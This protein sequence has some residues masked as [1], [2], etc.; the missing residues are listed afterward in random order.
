MKW[1]KRSNTL[2]KTVRRY[3]LAELFAP[4]AKKAWQRRLLSALP[5]SR[6]FAGE[7][8]PVRLRLALES[9][10]PVFVKFGQVLSTRPDLIPHDY[11]VELAKLQD[12]VPPFD[13]D[14]SR[15]Q[16]EKALGRPVARLYA[17]FETR[18]VASASVAQVHRARL[19][20]GERVAVKVLR[21]DIL[22][23][24]EQDLAL[25][26]F[27]AGWVER[28]FADGKRLR[29]REVV[30]EF[31]K[32]LHD[33]LDL[34]REA[35]NCS[36]LG[37]NFK[38]SKMLIV[39]KVFYDYCSRD[40]L[41]IEWMDGTPVSD[42]AA[43]RAQGQ[44]LHKL[45]E[46]GVETFFTQV[47]RDGFFHAD[48]HPGNILVSADNRYIALD[49]GIV[50]SLTDYDK[51]YLAINFLAFFNRD[52][53]RVATAHIESGWVPPETRAE[54]LEAAV[55]AVCE[56]VFNKPISQI[57]FGLVLMRLFEVSRRFNVEIQPQLVLLQKTLLNIEGLGRQLEP[58]LDLW[59]TAKPFLVK[60]MNEQVG[61][62]AFWRNLKNEAPDWA[63]MLP[64]LPRKLNALVDEARQKE[65]RDAYVHLVKIQ[66]RQSLWLAVIAAALVLI[67]LF[68]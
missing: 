22:P 29:P 3:G 46:Y 59:A 48:M 66:Q 30:D 12:K 53:H 63:E 1:L 7:P 4:L 21:P 50:G 64:A 49:F 37:R 5:P 24:I 20:G 44:D 8:L 14:V 65:M 32:Y 36:Q 60:W 38:D 17:E 41:T 27:G 16:I 23:V 28:L 51:R 42:I 13:A 25:L 45:A 26:R 10:G 62:K 15:R 68:K 67:V 61:P 47:F 52:Y 19:H 43:L 56:P 35:A 57:S 54:E 33:E 55:R 2:W 34:M 39:P 40:V 11:A 31:D 6:G 9:L 18:P 58:D